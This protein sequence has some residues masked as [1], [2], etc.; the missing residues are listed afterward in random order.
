METIE[1]V[2]LLLLAVVASRTLVRISPLPLPLP[3]VQI[4]LGTFIGAVVSVPELKPEVFFLLFLPPLLFLDGWRLPADGPIRDR[5]FILELALGLVLFTVI[6]VGFFINWMIPTMPLA[7]AFGL[8]AVL[9]PT[10]PVAVSAVGNRAPIPKRMMSILQGESLLNDA[11]GLTCL[12]FAI[13]AALTGTFSFTSA[14]LTFTWLAVG[15]IIVGVGLTFGIARMK[16]WIA[17]RFGEETG[18][19]IIISLLI[20]FGAYLLAERIGGSGILAAVAAGFTMS[21][22]ERSGRALAVTRIRRNAVWDT[23]S[24]AANGAI[25]ILLGEQLPRIMSNA[26]VN[27]LHSP[28]LLAGYAIGIALALLILRFLWVWAS[29]RFV[30]FKSARRGTRMVAPSWRLTW[31]MSLAGA[32]GT[33]T[34]AGI[35]TLPVMLSDGTA[36]PSRDLAIFLASSVI[37][38]SLVLASIGL[39]ALLKGLEFPPEPSHEAELNRA[40]VAAAEAAINSITRKQNELAQGRTDADLYADAAAQ[41]METYRQRIDGIAQSEE[42]ADDNR[43]THEI[44]RNFRITGLRAER[45]EIF[46]LVRQRQIDAESASKMVREIDLLEARYAT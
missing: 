28:Q 4:A 38:L 44:E 46:R 41:I 43:R 31:A 23:V 17:E 3:L 19:Q 37:I 26:T 15:G 40:R 9:S 39:P 33:V 32:R 30:M 13:A 10:D 14:L 5:W 25:F 34:L 1:T 11:T 24:Y 18:S 8:A 36:F 2:L 42:D 45:D 27:G 22:V 29:V 35:L 7:V 21:Y 16:D 12:R 20:P 6:G